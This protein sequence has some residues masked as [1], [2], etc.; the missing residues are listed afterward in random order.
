MHLLCSVAVT[1]M[2]TE[3]GTVLLVEDDNGTR[4]MVECA[5]RMEGIE[6]HVGHDGLDARRLLDQQVPD[7][8]VLDLDLP[9]VSGFDVQQE[10]VSHV[11][12]Q[13]IPIIIVT[14]TEWEVPSS[15][16]RTLR[17]PITPDVLIDVVGKAL[18]ASGGSGPTVARQFDN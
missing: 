16:F 12:T 13:A 11:E 3:R 14:A 9:Q 17:K 7:V 15:V 2:N 5:L 6:G 10:V 4:E 1:H 18:S 8:V